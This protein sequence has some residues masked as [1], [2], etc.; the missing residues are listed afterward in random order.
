M[1]PLLVLRPAPGDAATVARAAAGGLDA[2]AAPLFAIVPCAW[3]A[4]DAVRHD[5]LMLTSANA[6]RHAGPALAR[7]HVLPVYAVGEATAAAARAAGFADVRAGA[8]DAA[9]LVARMAGDGV[10]RVLHL[11]GRDHRAA[12]HPALTIARRIVYRADPV[13]RL[14]PAAMAALD[15]GAIVLLHSP[16]A[17]ALFARLAAAAGLPRA[18]IA[19]AAISRKAAAAAGPGWQAVAIAERPDDEALLAAARIPEP[20]RRRGSV[21]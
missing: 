6:V 7:Y 5:A 4:P 10:A 15:D 16:R 19:I 2:V 20:G 14:P 9:A 13:D 18:A 12:D 3:A 8:A 1:R 11:A 17:A 21:R